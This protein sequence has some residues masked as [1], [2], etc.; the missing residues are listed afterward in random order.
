MDLLGLRN[1]I[2]SD[3]I[4]YNT[5]NYLVMLFDYPCYHGFFS[6]LEQS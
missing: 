4:R 1:N 2:I 3:W 6:P 5:N